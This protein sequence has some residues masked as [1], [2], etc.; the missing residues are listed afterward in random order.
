MSC[1]PVR[2]PLGQEIMKGLFENWGAFYGPFKDQAFKPSMALPE[3]SIKNFMKAANTYV[4]LYR[5]WI[6]S[7]EKL[8]KEGKGM[9]GTSPGL[10]M[11]KGFYSSWMDTYKT[12]FDE[13]FGMPVFEPMKQFM[14]PVMGGPGPS[15]FMEMYTKLYKDFFS[16]FTPGEK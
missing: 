13:M 11:I 16:Q 14:G 4:R 12:V 6:D 7:F 9:L 10:E 1:P 3:D 8:S 15:G 2:P 5:S